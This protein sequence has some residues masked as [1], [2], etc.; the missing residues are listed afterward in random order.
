[1]KEKRKIEKGEWNSG[2]EQVVSK[3]CKKKKT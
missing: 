1:M 3:N 2:E